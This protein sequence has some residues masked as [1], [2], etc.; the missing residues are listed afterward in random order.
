MQGEEGNRN[1]KAGFEHFY[2]GHD[3]VEIKGFQEPRIMIKTVELEVE[4]Q[5]KDL[6][7]GK[8][9]GEVRNAKEDGTTE[10]LRPLPSEARMYPE[11]DLPLLRISKER[12]DRIK[13]ELPK[14]K[15]EIREELKKKGISGDMINLI[16]EN[17]DEF[18]ALM[19]V[20]DKNANLVGKMISLWRNEF[21]TKL[22]KNISE[23]KEILTERVMEEIL[24]RLRE[25]K[26]SE[27]DVKEI[28]FKI[29]SGEKL[30]N[31][32]K[33][34]KVGE[35]ELEEQI[36]NIIKEKPGLSA[37]AYMGLV[38]SKYGNKIDKR[39]AMEIINNLINSQ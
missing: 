27:G 17:I 15:S 25:G 9:E 23:I 4:R 28:L 32:L 10:Y 22:K 14:L 37:N 24:G 34:E 2:K 33:V 38:I 5:L 26:I 18:N 1:Y 8:K 13:K 31:A 6:E 21:A 12:I 39:K 35:S 36:R 29:A 30:E 16:I 7:S 3:R 19:R 20:Y 11:T